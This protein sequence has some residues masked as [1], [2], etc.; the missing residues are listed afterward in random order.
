MERPTWGPA[1]G[2]ARTGRAPCRSCIALLACLFLAAC[3]MAERDNRRTLNVLDGA[4]A[5]SSDGARWALAPV[6][7]P[8]GLV[9]LVADAVVVHPISVVD[10][11]WGDTVEWLWT[12]DPDESHFR[13]AMVVPLAALATPLVWT[14]AW[15]GRSV[16]AVPPREDG[17]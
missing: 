14:G 1:R 8:V 12:P 5:P 10:D 3:S 15:L 7:L 13:R 6:A 17:P 16:F 9:A 11:A 4:L 2:L